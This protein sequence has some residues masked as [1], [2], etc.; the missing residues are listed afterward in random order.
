MFLRRYQGQG[1]PTLGPWPVTCEDMLLALTK[2]NI[3]VLILD[4]YFFI[5]HDPSPYNDPVLFLI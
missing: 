1:C 2:A 3:F 4:G 5:F